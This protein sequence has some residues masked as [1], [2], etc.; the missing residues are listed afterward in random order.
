MKL[1]VV[2]DIH[3]N[4]T[5]LMRVLDA[6][7]K[8]EVDGLIIAGDIVGYYFEPLLALHLIQEFNKPVF[9]VRGNH[10]DMLLRASVSSKE[11]EDIARRY[12][13]GIQIALSQLTSSQI[14]YLCNLPHPLEINNFGCSILVSHGFPTAINKYVYPDNP[15]HEEFLKLERIPDVLIM[16]HTHYPFIKHYGNCLTINPGSVGQP[17]NRIP[18]AH[19]T[20]LDTNSMSAKAFIESY[21]PTDLINSCLKYA[22]DFPYLREVLVRS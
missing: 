4:A 21:D 15:L 14:H 17:R 3:A 5:A 11:S 13:P 1:A 8:A 2:A 12:G 7:K 22:P 6:A 18:G 16:G 19:W 20:L 10:E 9:T